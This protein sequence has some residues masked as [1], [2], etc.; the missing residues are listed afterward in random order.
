MAH[1]IKAIALN[2]LITPMNRAMSLRRYISR[3]HSPPSMQWV[4]I[5]RS[6]KVV[7]IAGRFVDYVEAH[8]G[9]APEKIKEQFVADCTSLNLPGDRGLNGRDHKSERAKPTETV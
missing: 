1:D 4:R 5:C 3:R 7:Q 8:S 6:K 9:L 2:I